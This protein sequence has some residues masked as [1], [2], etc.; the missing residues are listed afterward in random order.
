MDLYAYPTNPNSETDPTGLA[1]PQCIYNDQGTC[2]HQLTSTDPTVGACNVS[3]DY[4]GSAPCG[5][6]FGS[7]LITASGGFW[8]RADTILGDSKTQYQWHPPTDDP[9]R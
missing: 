5:V 3:I 2:T 4:G 7:G 9:E 1:P 6:A 8:W